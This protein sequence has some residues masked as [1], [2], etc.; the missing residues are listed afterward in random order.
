VDRKEDEKMLMTMWLRR[1]WKR[2]LVNTK[3]GNVLRFCVA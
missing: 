2:F 1:Q 3:S